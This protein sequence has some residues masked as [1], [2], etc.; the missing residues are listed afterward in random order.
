MA[1]RQWETLFDHYPRHAGVRSPTSGLTITV[2]VTITIT[3]HRHRRYR[4]DTALSDPAD[5]SSWLHRCEREE[6]RSGTAAPCSIEAQTCDLSCAWI[7]H[8]GSVQVLDSTR[9]RTAE[10]RDRSVTGLRFVRYVLRG[11]GDPRTQSSSCRPTRIGPL[12]RVSRKTQIPPDHQAEAT[13]LVLEQAETLVRTGCIDAYWSNK[14]YYP[15]SPVDD[16]QGPS[17]AT[18]R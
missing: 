12:R 15:R 1:T 9:S 5:G 4:I 13:K 17:Q 6:T 16:P 2:T 14:D 3:G 8:C 18:F 10:G 7:H 11:Q